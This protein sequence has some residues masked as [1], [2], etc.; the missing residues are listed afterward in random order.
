MKSLMTI[1]IIL[2]VSTTSSSC[3]ADET[4]LVPTPDFNYEFE[5]DCLSPAFEVV[6]SNLSQ[7]A[8]SYLWEFGDGTTSDDFEPRKVY[9]RS[10]KYTVTLKAIN[11]KSVTTISKEIIIPRNSNGKG[12]HIQFTNSMT[13]PT[14]LEITFVAESPEA[15]LFRWDFGDGSTAET[16]L[17]QIKHT[18]NMPG[19]YTVFLTA[20]NI[21]GSNCFSKTITVGP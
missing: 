21:D 4:I 5:G 13:D 15:T 7:N 17:K 14:K 6:F 16:D 19:D 20:S 12:P 8:T 1:S 3:S 2:C 11:A 18:Y 10:G 9:E